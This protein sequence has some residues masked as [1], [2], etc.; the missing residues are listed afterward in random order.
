MEH[1]FQGDPS[2]P[3]EER[4]V[5][6]QARGITVELVTDR[7]VFSKAGLDEGTRRLIEAVDLTGA[8]SALDLGCGYGPVTAI[9][10]RAY[11]GVKWWMIDVNRRAVEL[12]RR[13]TADVVPPPVVL[14]HD[15]IPR[16]IELRFDHVLLNPPIRAGKATVFRLYEE[17]R[18]A[19]K[20]GGKLWVVIQRKHGA[21]STE[22]KLRELFARVDIAHR[23]AGYFVFCA[24]REGS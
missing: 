15:G 9:L 18:R 8:A 12:A 17:A 4:V 21:P 19:L 11:P 13:N 22:V 20:P 1:Y 5:R 16:E 10:A 3:S 6:V 23:K 24:V 2:A 14:H 7:G